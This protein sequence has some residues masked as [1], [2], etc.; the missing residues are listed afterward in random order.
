MS[1]TPRIY[2]DFEAVAVRR[3]DL[4]LDQEAE[5]F[6][7]FGPLLQYWSDR[8]RGRVAPGRSDI[9]PLDLPL[10]L[11]PHLLLID[12]D[13]Q[14]LDFSYRLAGTVADTIHGRGLKGVR[15]LDL[16]PEDFARTLH[17]DL[18]RMSAE[19]APQF[20]ELAYVN[21]DGRIRRYRALRLPLCDE[22]GRMTM[23]LV[24]ADHGL[25]GR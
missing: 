7:F 11:L 13:R 20:V 2:D 21:R 14:P 12:V 24:L 3:T 8:R 15:V 18:A 25:A 4:A 10:P 6:A 16:R 22:A 9:D 17:D 23:V 5:D 19:P 1:A